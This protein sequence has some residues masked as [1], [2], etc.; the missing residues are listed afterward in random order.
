M[1]QSGTRGD[2]KRYNGWVIA[3]D[4]YAKRAFVVSE[5][6]WV[7]DMEWFILSDTSL[8]RLSLWGCPSDASL[9]ELI[10]GIFTFNERFSP[11]LWK[12][13]MMNMAEKEEFQETISDLERLTHPGDAVSGEQRHLLEEL[14]AENPRSLIVEQ[15]L[16]DRLRYFNA[17]AAALSN[18]AVRDIVWDY[19]LSLTTEDRTEWLNSE[20]VIA[21]FELLAEPPDVDASLSLLF[22]IETQPKRKWIIFEAHRRWP[23]LFRKHI[24]R[25]SNGAITHGE[26]VEW[27]RE[28]GLEITKRGL[29]FSRP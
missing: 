6:P 27:L 16:E 1:L 23:R 25:Y 3:K 12:G 7:E 24:D 11:E 26:Y 20:L 2:C 21:V 18:R 10:A 22:S 5:S 19:L 4:A 28:N 13:A 9:S 14:F 15:S 17:L 29:R 8:K